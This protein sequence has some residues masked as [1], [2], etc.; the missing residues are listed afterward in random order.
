[1]EDADGSKALQNVILQVQ[2]NHRIELERKEEKKRRKEAKA[3]KK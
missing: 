1:M 2:E 3:K